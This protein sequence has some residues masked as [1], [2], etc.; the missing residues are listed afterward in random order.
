MD[1]TAIRAALQGKKTFIIAGALVLLV[2]I[3]K[4]LGIDVPGF[5]PGPDWLET[6]L[7]AAGLSTL[8]SALPPRF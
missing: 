3:E 7:G 2:V 6:V 5:D 4:G 8:R 1:V